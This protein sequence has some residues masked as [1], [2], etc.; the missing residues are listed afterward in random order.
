MQLTV[1]KLI[2]FGKELLKF[3]GLGNLNKPLH[4]MIT[5]TIRKMTISNGNVS[6]LVDLERKYTTKFLKEADLNI[7]NRSNKHQ[8]LLSNPKSKSGDLGKTLYKKHK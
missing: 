5:V 6:S 4:K 1:Y 3:N 8:K 7:R 2:T